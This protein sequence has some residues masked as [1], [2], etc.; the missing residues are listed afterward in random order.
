MTK[1]TTK[2]RFLGAYES[3]MHRHHYSEAVIE[4]ALRD[5][6]LMLD[7]VEAG[8][9]EQWFWPNATTI[10]IKHNNGLKVSGLFAREL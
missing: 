4:K 5:T 9:V 8:H 2:Q 7:L 6:N 3:Y 10:V 1:T